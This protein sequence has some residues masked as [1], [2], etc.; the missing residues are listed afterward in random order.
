MRM[1]QN[2]NNNNNNNV[3]ISTRNICTGPTKFLGQVIGVSEFKSKNIAG[4]KLQ[5]RLTMRLIKDLLEEN[6]KPGFTSFTL[7]LPSPLILWLTVSL[8]L[9]F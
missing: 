1:L 4:K 5:E 8:S 7:F 2:N 6:I 3:I 9:L